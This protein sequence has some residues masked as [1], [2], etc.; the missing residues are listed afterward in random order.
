MSCEPISSP[1]P[2]LF[3]K[4]LPTP[5][6]PPPQTPPHPPAQVP[7]TLIQ[8]KQVLIRSYM[9]GLGESGGVFVLREEIG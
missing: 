4:P 2:N 7:V 8:V 5:P 6:L 1:C 9:S 3:L